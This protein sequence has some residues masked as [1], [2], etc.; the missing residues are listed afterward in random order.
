MEQPIELALFIS[1]NPYPEFNDLSNSLPIQLDAEYSE[2]N[3]TQCKYIYENL[4]DQIKVNNAS[5]LIY[6]LGG[7]HA[8]H[9]NFQIIQYY[10]LLRVFDVRYIFEDA[11]KKF[12]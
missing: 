5:V 4:T 12:Q 7:L 6:Q 9:C 2:F 11:L 3:H 10:T 8:L 1:L